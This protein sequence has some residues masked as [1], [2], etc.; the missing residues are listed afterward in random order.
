M[1]KQKLVFAGAGATAAAAALA[2]GFRR[3]HRTELGVLRTVESVDLPRY[4]GRWFEIARYPT[5]YERRCEKNATAEYTLRRG[6]RLYMENRC[7]TAAG[8]F[9]VARGTARLADTWSRAKMRVKYSCFARA[10]NYWIIDLDEDYRWAVIG[11]PKRR[12]LWILSRT[13]AMDEATYSG[14]CSRL[15][16]QGYDPD[17]LVRSPQD[18]A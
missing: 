10:A 11:E 3:P 12:L 4:A 16:T 8:K 18:G 2:L 14:I 5:R 1:D 9:D 6:N 15:V 7:T 17:K 13:P